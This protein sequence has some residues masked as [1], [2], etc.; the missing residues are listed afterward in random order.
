MSR[1]KK[2][3]H[4]LIL[5]VAIF[6]GSLTF[7]ACGEPKATKIRII[8][9]EQTVLINTEHNLNDLKLIVSYNKG[10]SKTVAK[11]NDMKITAI[12][13]TKEGK[14][15]LVV[16]YIGLTA[17]LEIEVVGTD[18]ELYGVYGFQKPDWQVK[19][20][21]YRD[22]LEDGDGDYNATAGEPLSDIA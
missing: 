21:S 1:I 11:N 15:N 12:D 20:E 6:F 14:Q 2:V 13:T 8:G 4:S 22:G 7:V 10:E 19:W 16:E 9:V 3:F 18:G 5:M 17:K